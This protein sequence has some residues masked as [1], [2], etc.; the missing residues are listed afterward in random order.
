MADK[1]PASVLEPYR[2]QLGT[3]PDRHIAQLAQVSR[4]IVLAW[5]RRLGIKPYQG[6]KFGS[7][8]R[9]RI[10]R[11]KTPKSDGGSFR[12]RRSAIDPH[13]ALLGKVPDAEI[14]RLAGVTTENVRMY[15][16]RR[17][18]AAE[19]QP[20]ATHTVSTRP[21]PPL[22]KA[23][24]PL[25]D[26]KPMMA[27]AVTVRCGEETRVYVLLAMDTPDAIRRAPQA[28]DHVW[29]KARILGVQQVGELI[30]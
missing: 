4:A 25:P 27:F 28:I 11:P 2:A 20:K 23:A 18:I 15:R 9:D 16:V 26:P 10:A 3:V 5:R 8:G 22:E 12:G 14:A 21:P 30:G 13:A 1:T 29:P 19:W 17:G 6:Y 24:Q 7:P